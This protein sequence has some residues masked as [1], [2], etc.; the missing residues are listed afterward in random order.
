MRIS[1]AAWDN[2]PVR[3]MPSSSSILPTPTEHR[4]AKSTRKRTV[5]SSAMQALSHG[6]GRDREANRCLA[7]AAQLQHPRCFAVENEF[8]DLAGHAAL[9]LAFVVRG[10]HQPAVRRDVDPKARIDGHTVLT[11]G[12]HGERDD[13]GV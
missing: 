9:M 3:A 1:R 7:R 8:D 5:S 10:R 12:G 2:D 6:G 4:L 11:G 13:A